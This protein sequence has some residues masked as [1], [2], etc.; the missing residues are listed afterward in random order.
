MKKKLSIAL[1][2]FSLAMLCANFIVRR[3][4]KMFPLSQEEIEEAGPYFSPFAEVKQETEEDKEI[5]NSTDFIVKSRIKQGEPIYIEKVE[6][7]QEETVKQVVKPILR[8]ELTEEE[9]K[10]IENYTKNPKLQSFIKEL[11]TVISPEELEQGNYLNIVYKP[12]VR[13]IFVKY[14]Q[15]ENFREIAETIIKYKNFLQFA[16]KIIKNNEVKK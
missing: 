15:D 2:A 3:V 12:E 7:P 5:I 9:Q 11:S 14:T 6:F 4:A 16:N 10:T 8:T 13:E 1:L